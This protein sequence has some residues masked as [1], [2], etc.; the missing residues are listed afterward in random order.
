MNEFSY[1]GFLF[2]MGFTVG[3]GFLIALSLGV[4][5]IQRRLADKFRKQ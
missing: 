2:G 3:T 1:M 4:T 5:F